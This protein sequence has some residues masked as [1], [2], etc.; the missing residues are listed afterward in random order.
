MLIARAPVRISLAGGGTD[1]PSYYR[2]HSGVVVSTTIDKYFYVFVS[3]HGS[4]TVQITSSDYHTFFRQRRGEPLLWNGDLTLPRAFLHQFGIDSGIS[5]FLA[6]EI[7]PGTGLGS[8]SAVAVALAKSLSTL[9]G[10]NL[11][12]AQLAQLASYVEIEKL[13]MPIGLQDQYAAAFGGL[14]RIDF[15]ADSVA[16]KPLNLPAE[17][18]RDLER[19]ILLFFTGISRSAA[20]V[21]KEQQAATR[22]EDSQAIASLHSIKAM[23]EATVGLLQSGRFEEYGALLAESW[24]AKKSLAR[25]ITNSR[26]DEWYELALAHGARGGKITG[27]GG[28]GF[29]MLYCEEPYQ[30]AVTSALEATG[31]VRMDFRFE[32][33]GAVVL[34]DALPR[35]RPLGNPERIRDVVGPAWQPVTLVQGADHLVEI[36]A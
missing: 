19:R 5:L 21:L 7:P 33:S 9:S 11:S 6:S 32:R 23:A 13:G 14:N 17:L 20:A 36:G 25:G 18:E 3:L 12:D 4:D 1:L 28:G 16:V 15:D 10:L 31:L 8:S 34:M 26:I 2:E 29:L 22:K 27:A 30:E 35:V 24:E